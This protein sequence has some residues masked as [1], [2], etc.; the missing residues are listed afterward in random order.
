[1]DVANAGAGPAPACGSN[2]GHNVW[3]EVTPTVSGL[4]TFS[5]CHPATSYDTVLQV[6]RDSGDCEFP[7]RLN[8]L[9]ID[10]S[11][12]PECNNGCWFGGKV[13][14]NATAGTTYFFQVGSYN[15]NSQGCTLC[16]GVRVTICGGDGTPPT[17]EITF[18]PPLGC[19]C[20]QEVIEGS[21]YDLDGAFDSYELEYQP[22]G[23]G[24][25]TLITSSNTPVNNGV[26]GLWN[27]SGLSHGWYYLRLTAKNA[28]GLTS[29]AVDFVLVDKQFDS[30]DLRSPPDLAVVGGTVCLDGTVWDQSCF[31]SYTAMYRPAAG[32]SFNPVDPG[33]PVYYNSV[34]N[35]PLASWDTRAGVPDGQYL[36]RIEGTDACGHVA[37]ALREVLV[38]NTAPIA[39][40]TNPLACQYLGGLVQVMGTASD[41]NLDYWALFFTG[42]NVN[43]WVEIGSG[44]S[45]VVNGV[46]A[47]W[48]T[49]GLP[50]CAY[51]LRL[52]VVDRA[53]IDCNGAIRNRSEYTVSFNLGNRFDTDGDGDVDLT[54]F[55]VFQ[56]CFGGSN[57]PPAPTCP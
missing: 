7:V 20:N 51:T 28:C 41:A 21:A 1:M 25:W 52:V 6:W 40:I 3:F 30:L 4:L 43:G 42:G 24:S 35:D 19:V 38:D 53:V 31:G 36:L 8:D 11:E 23:G 26:L 56:L 48:N 49:A 14:F 55:L 45:P 44:T 57:N 9:C 50:S 29:T 27:T 47:N 17:A 2:V 33:N 32:G 34:I 16:L 15:N 10:D 12:Y 37:S 13:T 18:P 54:D 39:V 5:T 22:A 46:L